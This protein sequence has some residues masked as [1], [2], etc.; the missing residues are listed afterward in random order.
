MIV[1]SR[2]NCQHSNGLVSIGA[3]DLV[4][5]GARRKVLAGELRHRQHIDISQV[6]DEIDPDYQEHAADH[7]TDHVAFGIADL[8]AK[9]DH[10]VPTVVGVEHALQRDD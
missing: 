2:E 7:R 9:I 6:N 4:G 10:A 5:D 3:K 8:F 1:L